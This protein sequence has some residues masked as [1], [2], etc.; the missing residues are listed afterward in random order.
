[1][2]PKTIDRLQLDHIRLRRVLTALNKISDEFNPSASTSSVAWDNK[3]DQI[4]CMIDYLSQYPD[5]I[6]HPIEDMVFNRVQDKNP[7]KE[8]LKLIQQNQ[9][10]HSTLKE[11]T[12]KLKGYLN[13]NASGLDDGYDHKQFKEELTIYCNHQLSHM[14]HE[15]QVIFPLAQSI[16]T[17]TDWEEID[18]LFGE[19]RDPIFD[20][21]ERQ[22]EGIYQHLG[23]E[24]GRHLAAAEPLLRFLNASEAAAGIAANILEQDAKLQDNPEASANNTHS[25]SE[26][27]DWGKTIFDYQQKSISNYVEALSY[28]SSQSMAVVAFNYFSEQYKTNLEVTNKLAKAWSGGEN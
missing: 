25:S 4:F 8:Q 7:T 24:P 3:L 20:K 13:D 14:Q 16:L 23:V 2:I 1:M 22:Y 19:S 11:L 5:K 27:N 17:P 10:Q 26:V 6:H 9:I 28:L 15:E 21:L 12:D 18:H